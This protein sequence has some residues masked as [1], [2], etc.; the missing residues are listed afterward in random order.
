MVGA[1]GQAFVSHEYAEVAGAAVGEYG[2][3]RSHSL[4]RAR[5]AT[6]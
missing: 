6:A 1:G 4:R 2:T 5:R 3:A